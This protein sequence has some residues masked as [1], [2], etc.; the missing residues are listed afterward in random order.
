MA[1]A[2]SHADPRKSPRSETIKSSSDLL[3]EAREHFQAEN[4]DSASAHA[5]LALMVDPENKRARE[6]LTEI[7]EINM[8]KFSATNSDADIRGY[9]RS[10]VHLGVQ[11]TF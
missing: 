7:D 5:D 11:S 4:Y 9:T 6:L 2:D 1:G 3:S 10:R 8:S